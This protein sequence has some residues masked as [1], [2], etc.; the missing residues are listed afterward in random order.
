L[1]TLE[2]VDALEA[3]IAAL[4]SHNGSAPPPESNPIPADALAREMQRCAVSAADVAAATGM[5]RSTVE[6]W[7]RGAR[8]V[9][10]WIL[11]FIRLTAELPLPARRRLN[12]HAPHAAAVPELARSHPFARIEEL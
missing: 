10:A 5:E 1:T 8:P 2:L 4:R 9:P 12:R 11:A 7:I 6:E 3:G